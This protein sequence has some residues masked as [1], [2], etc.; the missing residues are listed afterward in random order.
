MKV[1]V[2]DGDNG[3]SSLMAL[4]I[5]NGKLSPPP[6]QSGVKSDAPFYPLFS[7]NTGSFYHHKGATV[8]TF[9]TQGAIFTKKNQNRCNAKT[10][11]VVQY[12]ALVIG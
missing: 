2:G 10:I 8:W 6:G 3:G 4:P 7:V 9:L 11:F 5:I 1:L 12:F